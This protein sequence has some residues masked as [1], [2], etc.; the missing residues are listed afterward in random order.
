[1]LRLIG[2]LKVPVA[3]VCGPGRDAR[4]L[5][6]CKVVGSERCRAFLSTEHLQKELSVEVGCAQAW[7]KGPSYS[8]SSAS[9]GEGRRTCSP[10]GQGACLVWGRKGPWSYHSFSKRTSVKDPKPVHWEGCS[11]RM[12]PILPRL[13]QGLARGALSLLICRRFSCEPH[14]SPFR[15]GCSAIHILPAAFSLFSFCGA[16]GGFQQRCRAHMQSTI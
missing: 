2:A 10:R 12:S 9:T 8:A 6:R 15:C 7:V 13:K 14:P 3:Y 11:I 16:L 5:G 4:V 1:M